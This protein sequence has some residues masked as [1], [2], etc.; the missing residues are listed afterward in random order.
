MSTHRP[1]LLRLRPRHS[2]PGELVIFLIAAVLHSEDLSGIPLLARRLGLRAVRLDLGGVTAI[3]A[4]GVDRLVD[5]HRELSA[6]GVGLS[7]CH[8]SA[9]LPT[10]LDRLRGLSPPP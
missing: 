5:L 9:A 10:G 2:P 1:R 7:V 3:P 6:L 8:A 4:S